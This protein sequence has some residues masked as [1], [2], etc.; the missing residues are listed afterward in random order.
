MNKNP[1]LIAGAVV[2]AVLVGLSIFLV[3]KMV[4]T[5]GEVRR[6]MSL[7]PTPLPPIPDTVRARQAADMGYADSWMSI[8]Y[9]YDRGL[10]VEPDEA[11][12]L[13]YYEKAASLGSH[14]AYDYL[15]YRYLAGDR[16]PADPA[17][18]LEYYVKAA[19]LGNSRSMYA[20][21]YA[22][23]HGEGVDPDPA[24]AA[25]WYELAAL[26]GRIDAAEAL[27]ALSGQ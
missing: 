9:C 11:L 14:L 16:V 5:I 26:A 15:G 27:A 25:R 4:P 12:A 18:G 2:L 1:K 22:Y 17:R 24:E 10:G 8:A 20:L 13:E 19:E 6:E 21:G 7:T 23:E 3:I